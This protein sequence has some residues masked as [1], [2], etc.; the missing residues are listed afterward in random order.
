[1]SEFI[2]EARGEDVVVKIVNATWNMTCERNVNITS[3]VAKL[4]DCYHT[5]IELV[6]DPDDH[7]Y[8]FKG[9]SPEANYKLKAK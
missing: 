6:Y 4:D 3:D 7:E 5:N 9:G 1:M 2:F 8:P